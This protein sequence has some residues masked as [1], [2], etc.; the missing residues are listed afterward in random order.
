MKNIKIK[1][2]A[3]Y[4]SISGD[5]KYTDLLSPVSFNCVPGDCFTNIIIRC[6]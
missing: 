6:Y 1:T 5:Y 2:G 3:I 4:S